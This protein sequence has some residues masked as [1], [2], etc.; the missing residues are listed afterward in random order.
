MPKV[1]E[2]QEEVA[3]YKVNVMSFVLAGR[4]YARVY[5]SRANLELSRGEGTFREEAEEQAIEIARQR[6]SHVRG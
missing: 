2:R 5:D 4:Y 3:G 1:M 6:L